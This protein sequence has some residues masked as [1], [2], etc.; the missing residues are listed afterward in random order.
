MSIYPAGELR[1]SLRMSRAPVEPERRDQ[2]VEGQRALARGPA[3]EIGHHEAQAVLAAQSTVGPTQAAER[4]PRAQLGPRRAVGV[5]GGERVRAA[6]IIDGP[7]VTF[8]DGGGYL[9][10]GRAAASF[11]A[12]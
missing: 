3:W 10:F 9:W 8:F 4:H 1:G 6:A 5:P 2:L 7:V 12:R 11:A